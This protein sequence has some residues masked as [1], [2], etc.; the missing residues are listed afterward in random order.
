MHTPCLGPKFVG[1]LICVKNLEDTL[2]LIAVR[3]GLEQNMLLI[4]CHL[5]P[6]GKAGKLV[7]TIVFITFSCVLVTLLVVV[8]V[9]VVSLA[10]VVCS[11]GRGGGGRS[12]TSY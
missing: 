3:S 11:R 1:G 8:F 4:V 10:V 9:F 7:V 5:V 12:R 2:S 6:P